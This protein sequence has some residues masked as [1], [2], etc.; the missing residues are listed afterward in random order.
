L[1]DERTAALSKEESARQNAEDQ[2][3]KLEKELEKWKGKATQATAA[4]NG[5]GRYVETDVKGM[6]EENTLLKVSRMFE[7]L[8]FCCNTLTMLFVSLQR[9]LKCSSCRQKF[10]SHTITRCF[11]M[12]C[13][14]CI[15]S[16]LETRQRKCPSCSAAFG[17]HDVQQVYF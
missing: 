6:A 13:K 16:R 1:F 17:A 10:K 2:V 7:K 5:Q 9:M 14:D 15:D 8:D 11:H 12:F 4:A 3:A